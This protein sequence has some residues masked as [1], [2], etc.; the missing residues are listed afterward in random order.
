VGKWSEVGRKDLVNVV[1][2]KRGVENKRKKQ[3]K[4]Q[5]FEKRMIW[6]YN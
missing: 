4:Q 3:K 6:Q 5:K 2:G 1:L